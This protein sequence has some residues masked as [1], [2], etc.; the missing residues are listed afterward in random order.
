MP[1]SIYNK[2]KIYVGIQLLLFII[3][4]ISPFP[5]VFYLG[6]F[7][8]NVSLVFATAGLIVLMIA[9]LQ[10]NRNLSPFPT[11]VRNSKLL[12]NGVYAYIRHPIYGGILLMATGY[13]F[14]SS[15]AFRLL[16]TVSLLLLFYL[17]SQYEEKLMKE[18][19][20]EYTKYMKQTGRFCPL[21]CSSLRGNKNK[22]S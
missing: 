18:R 8:R 14:Y 11:P 6:E 13:S 2:D 5:I 19:F 7:W 12:Q 21:N 4:L 3:Y 15:D 10:L 16:I 22:I 20:L 1:G 17:K 9:V